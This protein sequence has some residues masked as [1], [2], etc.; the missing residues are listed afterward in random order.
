MAEDDKYRR[1]NRQEVEEY[2]NGS[3]P[4]P[5]KMFT[6]D[7]QEHSCKDFKDSLEVFEKWHNKYYPKDSYEVLRIKSARSHIIYYTILPSETQS[8]LNHKR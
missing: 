4:K 8:T 7:C 1:F 5:V 6:V 2:I 3:K